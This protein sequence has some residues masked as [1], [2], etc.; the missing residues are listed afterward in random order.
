MYFPTVEELGLAERIFS[1][2]CQPSG[3][4]LQYEYRD[5]EFSR[6]VQI[7]MPTTWIDGMPLTSDGNAGG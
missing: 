7:K 5:Y 6:G 4:G 2:F 1:A 3:P